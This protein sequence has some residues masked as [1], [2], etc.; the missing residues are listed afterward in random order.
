MITLRTAVALPVW[1]GG[2]EG[3]LIRKGHGG[4]PGNNKMSYLDTRVGYVGIY[5]CQN[6]STSNLKACA[7]HYM[8]IIPP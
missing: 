3:E 5:I 2:W 4:A 1:S 7:F 8:Q 6:L